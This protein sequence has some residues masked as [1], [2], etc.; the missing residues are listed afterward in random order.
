M[1]HCLESG[2]W[3]EYIDNIFLMKLIDKYVCN[4]VCGEHYAITVDNSKGANIVIRLNE[5]G[6]RIFELL[7]MGKNETE[8]TEIMLCEY[9]ASKDEITASIKQIVNKLKESALIED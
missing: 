6:R 4:E 7:Q 3:V 8:I 9:E 5:S 2:I 1:Y